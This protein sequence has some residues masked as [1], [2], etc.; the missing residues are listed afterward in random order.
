MA[1]AENNASKRANRNVK[2]N[3]K[4]SGRFKTPTGADNYAV[5]R[6][7]IDTMIKQGKNVHNLLSQIA[8]IDRY[9]WQVQL[10]SR[11]Q[12]KNLNI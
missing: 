8:S 5:T 4:I 12:D 6:S 7:I 9:H 10:D 1:P 3:Q 2:V 11:I